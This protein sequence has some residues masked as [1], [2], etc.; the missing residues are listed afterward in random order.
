MAKKDFFINSV[1]LVDVQGSTNIPTLLFY[2]S[3]KRNPLF[4]SDA[5]A[6]A[7]FRAELNED[8]KVDLG[9]FKPGS[10]SPPRQ[11][12]CADG[13]RRSASSLTADFLNELIRETRMWLESNK[14]TS[15]LSILVAE[16]L[17]M[18]DD[19]VSDNWLTNY[20]TTIRRLL[21]GKGFEKVDFM[22]EP[23]A[24]YQYYRHGERHPIL[25]EQRKH[26]ALVLDFGGGTF[27]VCLIETTKQ[28]DVASG[29]PM[30]KPLSASSKAVGGYYV[31]RIIA[32]HLVRKL[33]MPR[34]IGS[35]LQRAFHEYARWRKDGMEL[36]SFTPE[37]GN[38]IKNF[39]H[40]IYRVE[41][42]KLELSRSIR[43]WSLE[44]LDN[45][46]VSVCVPED[47]FLDDPSLVHLQ[48]SSSEFRELFT[49]RIWDAELK[50]VLKLALERGKQ[51]SNGASVSVVLLSGGSANI[52]WLTEL[53]KKDFASELSGAEILAIKDY[54]EVVSK[55][56]AIECAR[57]FYTTESLGD[58][59]A[60]TYNRLCLLLDPDRTGVEIKRFIPKG[61]STP[62][63]DS[64]ASCSQVPVLSPP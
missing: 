58:F 46:A 57:R 51:E 11:F 6:A 64:L 39:H 8:F 54:Q 35:K 32:E 17:S 28:G 47:P 34:N 44:T 62:K 19:L 33:L 18:Q 13:Q 36:S 27:D 60:V 23:F 10:S 63:S 48:F 25:A 4:G 3:G 16:P 20:R 43:K 5:I 2:E 12:S 1:E 37:Y 49:K 56:I 59:S 15:D 53:L 14:L 29:G 31:N 50:N 41:G 21:V 55:G 45:A 26:Y 22:P 40:L 42:S 61:D 9:N 7:K 52:R 24:V 38:F 30:A